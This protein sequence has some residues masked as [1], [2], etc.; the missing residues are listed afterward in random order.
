MRKAKFRR[1]FGDMLRFGRV[2]RTGQPGLDVAE[3]AGPCAGVAHDH[4]GGVF[5]FPTLADIWA[6]GLL[7][8]RVQ[9]VIAH[10]PLS[11]EIPRGYGCLDADPCRLGKDGLIR[12][13]RFFRMTRAACP[14]GNSIDQYGHRGI[15]FPAVSDP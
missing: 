3:G 13:M 4:E 2:E 15:R 14:S 7:A 8:H 5:L 10:D 11:F 1:G 9:I 12:P 6:A